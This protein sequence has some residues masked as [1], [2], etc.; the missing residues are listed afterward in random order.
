[1][2]PHNGIMRT[3]VR[4][5][6]HLLIEAKRLAATRR[7]SL[8]KVVEDSLRKYLA[9]ARAEADRPRPSRELPV[10]DAGTVVAGVDLDD[11]S[12]L[13]EL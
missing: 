7:T 6:D 8:A 10:T 12:E 9:E 2:M 5:A 4:I 13:L 11:T 1:M 3:T